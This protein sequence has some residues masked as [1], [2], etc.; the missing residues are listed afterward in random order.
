MEIAKKEG[1]IDKNGSKW[2]TMPEQML[3]YRSASWFVRAYAPEISM[4]LQ[5]QEE[6]E[7]VHDLRRNRDGSYTIID[8]EPKLEERSGA[9]KLAALIP[10]PKSQE[11]EIPSVET[12]TSPESEPKKRGRKPKEPEPEETSDD[13]VAM[14]LSNEIARAKT[15]GDVTGVFADAQFEYQQG[16]LSKAD[17]D[18]ISKMCEARKK[19]IQK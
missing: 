7:D 12:E 4:G 2:R 15:V 17:F 13:L 3:M 1:W 16:N 19:E 10:K 6:M 14:E 18:L 11:Q 8:N 9:S 5:T